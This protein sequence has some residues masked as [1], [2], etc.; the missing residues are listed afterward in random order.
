MARRRPGPARARPSPAPALT[1]PPRAVLD[2]IMSVAAIIL[3]RRIRKA[4]RR[5]AAGGR[6]PS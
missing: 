3:E 2:T 4:L 5:H 6:P 1:R